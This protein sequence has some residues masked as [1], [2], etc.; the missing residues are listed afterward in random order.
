MTRQVEEKAGYKPKTTESREEKPAEVIPEA[1]TAESAPA[2]RDVE[3]SEAKVHRGEADEEMIPVDHYVSYLNQGKRERSQLMT[4]E[5]A[6]EARELLKQQ[7]ATD[8]RIYTTDDAEYRTKREQMERDA[9]RAELRRRRKEA[10]EAAAETTETP[11]AKPTFRQFVEGKGIKWPLLKEDERYAPLKAEYDESV[12][13]KAS[14]KRRRRP[15][16]QE[17]KTEGGRGTEKRS[18]PKKNL[19]N[20]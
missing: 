1:E 15:S 20:L 14:R 16:H 2:A 13:G 10:A 17:Q 11:A 4:K 5:E 9:Y 6:E 3:V 19:R 8:I 12:Q 7:G 18:V